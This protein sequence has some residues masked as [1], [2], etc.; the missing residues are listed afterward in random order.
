[1]TRTRRTISLVASLVLIV[2]AFTPATVFAQEQGGQ[3][4]YSG[5]EAIDD[6]GKVLVCKYVDIPGENER[7][8]DGKNPIEVNWNSLPGVE[9]PEQVTI[10][11]DWTDAHE[12]SHVVAWGTTDCP[13]PDDGP[14]VFTI[15]FS[16][17]WEGD[18]DGLTDDHVT[19]TVDGTPVAVGETYEVQPGATLVLREEVTS[20]EEHC[21]YVSDLPA[22]WLVPE[23]EAFGADGHLVIP[24]TNQVTCEDDG[25]PGDDEFS[26]V[27]AKVWTG[28]TEG[29]DL[30][31]D[32]VTFTIG[33]GD[34]IAVGD[35]VD[36]E[37]GSQLDIV[38]HF[39]GELDDGCTFESDLTSPYTV[40]GADGFHDGVYTLTVTNLVTCEDDGIPGDDEFSLVFAKVWT[41]DTEGLDLSDDDVTFTIGAGDPI[42]VGDHVDVEPG[43]QL[44]IVEHFHGELDDGCTFESDLTSPYT[45]PG[46]DGFHDGVYTLTVTNLV[47]CEDEVVDEG[48]I[49]IEKTAV[50]VGEDNTVTIDQ[51]GGSV[52]VDYEFVVTNT[53]DTELTVDTLE[54]TTIGD[55]SAA[56]LAEHG[57]TTL[58][59]GDEVTFM[60]TATLS[61]DDFD[62]TGEHT[63]VVTVTTVE[64]PEAEADETV[65]LVGVGGEDLEAD[66]SLEKEALVTPD[67]DGFRLVELGADG[68]V[69][70][71]YRFTITN[72]G[73]I[74]LTLDDFADSH[75]GDL[76]D[77][78]TTTTLPAGGEPLVLELTTTLTADDFDADEGW[79]LNVAFVTTEEG[80][81][82]EAEEIIYLVDVLDEV[83]TPP[84]VTPPT[85]TPPT[86][87]PS[88]VTPPTQVLGVVAE[89]A[90]Q[91][92]VTGSSLLSLLLG[93]LV[94]LGL[95]GVLLKA[96]PARGRS[97]TDRNGSR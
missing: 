21:T 34:P 41:G 90:A 7:L 22:T 83:V 50:G 10:G 26:L 46:A 8:K 44:D 36:V 64:G 65:I 27:F 61:A 4:D 89:R 79:H 54:D 97:R 67:A 42:A 62:E 80:P 96:Q 5:I 43:S 52:D 32:D 72:T 63:N 31:D 12:R 71:T 2:A 86:V 40:P 92:P 6:R 55:L 15:A 82:D 94:A 76:I 59:V 18:A 47:T 35:H 48:A 70:V 78:L 69:D 33:A 11:S 91:L 25:I 17:A 20:L 39:H 9:D 19:F 66:I 53:G 85:V 73:D 37:P 58:A 16:K 29:L 75:L 45:V 13:A 84:T 93:A 49:A 23:A 74:D 68:T 81:E 56:F 30:S 95:G 28:D 1:M 87:T 38:E 77:E 51:I 57:S 3:H 14:D 24:V 60:A 88:T